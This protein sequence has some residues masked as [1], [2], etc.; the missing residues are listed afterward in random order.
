MQFK[1][2]EE[3]IEF[4]EKRINYYLESINA[5]D[6]GRIF[7]FYKLWLREI[8]IP[9][10]KKLKK[11]Y[12]SYIG[13][14]YR[15]ENGYIHTKAIEYVDIEYIKDGEIILVEDLD[16]NPYYVYVKNNNKIILI[17]NNLLLKNE[18]KKDG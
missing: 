11:L 16:Y 18:V 10:Y 8:F 4:E 9:K 1:N 3:M 7:T 14:W 15:D 13:G 6:Q 5:I 17:D 2:R 12:D